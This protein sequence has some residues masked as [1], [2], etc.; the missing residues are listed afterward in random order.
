MNA[1]KKFKEKARVIKIDHLSRDVMTA[2]DKFRTIHAMEYLR[3]FPP[4]A[5]LEKRVTRVEIVEKLE[6]ANLDIE[7][8]KE[9]A[10]KLLMG[11][12]LLVKEVAIIHIVNGEWLRALREKDQKEWVTEKE[13]YIQRLLLS[14]TTSRLSAANK[15][16]EGALT[17]EEATLLEETFYYD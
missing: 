15:S 11:R 12:D 16:G 13:R 4:K 6:W 8:I 3:T 17:L 14:I 5:F 9:V 7:F 2:L 1:S 10:Y